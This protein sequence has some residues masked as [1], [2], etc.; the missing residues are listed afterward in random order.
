MSSCAA[1]EA[2]VSAY[3]DG[4]LSPEERTAL[5]EHME[6]CRAC[7]QYFDDQ[8]ALHEAL[9]SLED[10][11]APADL[12]ERVMAQVRLSA[13]AKGK[14]LSLPRWGRWAALAACCAVAALGLWRVQSTGGANQAVPML[15]PPA[16]VSQD[17]A[18]AERHDEGGVPQAEAA[19][20][21]PEAASAAQE[22]QEALLADEAERGGGPLRAAAAE[23]LTLEEA[24]EGFGRSLA[25]CG[26][27]RFLYCTLEAGEDGRYTRAVYV[28]TFGEIAVIDQDLAPLPD[29]G[30][31][32]D[33]SWEGRDLRTRDA[34]AGT[35]LLYQPSGG[36][37][38]AYLAS[39]DDS[40]AYS[41]AAALLLSLE[42]G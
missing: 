7:R 14:T 12:A 29:A 15:Q 10:V 40:L 9:L 13:P 20:T 6:S 17:K 39:Y 21:V 35:D 33:A 25:A 18:E 3:L 38:L 4:A 42:I 32:E 22:P 11:P 31:W 2:L 27:S 34:P 1:Y 19:L 5:A 28:F 37:G 16:A 24:S 26:D 30:E 41:D 36:E 23:S 8:V